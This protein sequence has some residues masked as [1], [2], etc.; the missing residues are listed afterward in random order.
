VTPTLTFVGLLLFVGSVGPGYVYLR[1]S[2]KREPRQDRTAL[3]EAAELFVVGTLATGIT[4]GILSA[5]A[6]AMKQLDIVRLTRTPVEYLANQPLRVLILGLAAIILSHLA[7]W[8]AAR[9]VH[10]GKEASLRPESTV[11]HETF[12]RVAI[13]GP[14]FVTLELV[15]GR[16]V[17]GYLHTYSIDRPA[18]PRE[19]SLQ[20]PIFALARAMNERVRVD[21]DFFVIREDRI[22][23]LAV[24]G[25]NL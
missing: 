4:V 5:G 23:N 25:H 17:S 1:T 15:D 21:A 12:R 3:I 13:G 22:A 9:I 10:A 7:A 20:K 2:E 24:R 6:M 8:G 19:I 11:W 16:R 14:V 18:E